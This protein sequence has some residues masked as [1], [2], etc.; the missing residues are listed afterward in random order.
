MYSIIDIESNGAGFRKESIIEIAIFKYD[1]HQIV[2]QFIS[3]VNPEADITPFVQKLTQIYPKM[4]KTAPKFH[5]IAKRIIEITQGTT[6]VGHNIDF[7]Y[8][9]LRQSFERLGYPFE[10]DT[11]DTIPL[12]K[13]LIPDAESY[14]LCK[15]TK[16]LGIALSNHHR[17]SGDARAT[18]DLFRLLM[19]K[20]T[21]Q[22]IL[23]K[24]N[25]ETTAKSY[26]NKIKQLTQNLPNQRGIVYFQDSKGKIL[27]FDFSE[28]CNRFAK[29]VLQSK[30]LKRKNIQQNCEQINFELTGSALLSQL[31][32]L[33]KGIKIKQSLPFGLFYKQGKYLVEK[34]LLNQ[35]I[36]PMVKF[37]SFT[38]GLKAIAYINSNKNL[39]HP[40]V[41]SQKL[42][43]KKTNE[44]WTGEGRKLGEKFFLELKN[45]TPISFGFYEFY[46]Q[47]Q[48]QEKINLLKI[49]LANPPKELINELQLSLLKDDLKKIQTN[50]ALEETASD[51]R[52]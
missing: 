32:L 16:S 44:I 7:D 4:V 43:L 2:D 28:N 1:G 6:L 11:L 42:N 5:E 36:K 8:R 20:D 35:E 27:H 52:K 41:L 49:N 22:E 13:K 19:S 21:S 33:S 3:L 40:E 48:S 30:S 46:T 47:I 45:G 25:D 34:L 29:T 14:S 50:S 37:K 12:A 17:A 26:T 39:Q 51:K 10:I 18:L 31:I 24:Q 38:Q 15:L 23:Q 9:M